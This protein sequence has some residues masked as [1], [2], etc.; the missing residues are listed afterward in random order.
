MEECDD[1]QVW[2]GYE[3][4]Q[5]GNVPVLI[6]SDKDAKAY[7]GLFLFNPD[8]PELGVI[9]IGQLGSIIID[10]KNK[11]RAT[12]LLQYSLQMLIGDT[13]D[14]YRPTELCGVKFGEKGAYKL[15]KDC[16]TEQDAL[17]VVINQYKLWY[18]SEFSY[19]TWDGVAKESSWKHMLNLYHCC[20]RMKETK[21]D[22]LIAYDFYRRFN[23]NLEE[24]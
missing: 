11:V 10:D 2:M 6:A 21:D 17:L 8:K 18:P 20:V 4:L 19:N 22:A 15:L 24:H 3:E 16:T 12:G 13:V 9:E 23:I 5:K 7:S 14:S 1:M